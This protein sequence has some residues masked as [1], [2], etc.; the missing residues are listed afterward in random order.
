MLR[1]CVDAVVS[2]DTHEKLVVFAPGLAMQAAMDALAPLEIPV[3]CTLT[4]STDD[5][6]DF[7]K[8]GMLGADSPRVLILDYAE[9]VG[10]NLQHVSSCVV[11]FMPEYREDP[12]DAAAATY[13]ATRRVYR[14]GQTEAR[15]LVARIVLTHGEESEALTVD[16]HLDQRN[17]DDDIVQ[18]AVCH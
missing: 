2:R 11:L 3:L 13:Q 18:K 9:G 8:P 1:Q 6:A 12:V 15:V 4:A 10:L 5:I 16:E 17:F 14:H 7:A